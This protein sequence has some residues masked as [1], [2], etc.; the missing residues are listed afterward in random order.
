MLHEILKLKKIVASKY[1]ENM[2]KKKIFTNVVM[3]LKGIGIVYKSIKLKIYERIELIRFLYWENR[4]ILTNFKFKKRIGKTE[5]IFFNI[6][7]FLLN[8]YSWDSGI[9]FDASL[10]FY[11]KSSIKI[12]DKKIIHIKNTKKIKTSTKYCLA[13]KNSFEFRENVHFEL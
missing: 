7:N 13:K 3:F 8:L 1:C 4:S 6:Y 9:Y 12:I 2:R 5:C 10:S 11:L